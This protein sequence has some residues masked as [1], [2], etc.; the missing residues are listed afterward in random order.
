MFNYFR[1]IIVVLEDTCC[2]MCPKKWL[3]VYN[4]EDKDILINT[5]AIVIWPFFS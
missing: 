1:V 4:I 5:T 3:L 2:Y